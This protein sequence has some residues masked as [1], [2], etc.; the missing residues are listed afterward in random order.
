MEGD[1]EVVDLRSRK[2]LY[3]GSLEHCKTIAEKKVYDIK[4]SDPYHP[5]SLLRRKTK[6]WIGSGGNLLCGFRQ[7]GYDY[8]TPFV[9][10]RKKSASEADNAISQ[11][12]QIT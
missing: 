2:V 7:R 1:Y 10:I 9:A 3:D 5:N 11:P 4:A 8:A 6:F 12:A